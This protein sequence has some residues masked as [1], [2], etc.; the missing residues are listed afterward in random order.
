M[1]AVAGLQAVRPYGSVR[2]R[3]KCANSNGEII[4]SKG[5]NSKKKGKNQPTK[6]VKEKKQAKRDKKEKKENPGILNS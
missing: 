5:Q 6:T 4:M 1:H 3:P 2:N